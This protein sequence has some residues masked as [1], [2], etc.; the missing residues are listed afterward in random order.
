MSHGSRRRDHSQQCAVPGEKG[1]RVTKALPG[2]R[3]DVGTGPKCCCD[4]KQVMSSAMV[5]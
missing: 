4:L 5:T 1:G 3:G 2:R